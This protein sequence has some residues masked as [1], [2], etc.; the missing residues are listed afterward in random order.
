MSKKFT[1]EYIVDAVEQMY[2]IDL[3]TRKKFKLNE[4]FD[5]IEKIYKDKKNKEI[6]LQHLI[7]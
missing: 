5:M 2:N 3:N 1:W 4:I 6:T 7:Q